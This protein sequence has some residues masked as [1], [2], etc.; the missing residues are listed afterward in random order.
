M[1]VTT[2]DWLDFGTGRARFTG[3]IRGADERGHETFA[4]EVDGAEY[5]GE[6]DRAFLPNG[7]DFNMEIVSFGYTDRAYVSA[8][9]PSA[10]ET[11]TPAA[12]EVMQL[13]ICRLV[14]AVSKAA[15][16]PS[17]MGEYPDAHFMGK[18]FFR[19]GWALV[20]AAPEAEG[21]TT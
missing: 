3:G 17:I 1:G 13:L 20:V 7:N 21:Q 2:F 10:R 19:E 4:V 14:E 12:L 16:K 15:E 8:P 5:F 6:I 9:F 18:V 11:F